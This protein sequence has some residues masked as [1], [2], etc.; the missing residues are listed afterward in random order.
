MSGMQHIC[1]VSSALKVMS[2][3]VCDVFVVFDDEDSAGYVRR[4]QDPAKWFIR[5]RR[6]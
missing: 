4:H 1:C 6:A 2:Y 5:D 3:D